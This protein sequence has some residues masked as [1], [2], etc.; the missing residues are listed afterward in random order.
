MISQREPWRRLWETRAGA[1][2]WALVLTAAGLSGCRS[3]P[4]PHLVDLAEPGWHVRQGQAVWTTDRGAVGVAGDLVVAVKTDASCWV[5]FSKP[6]FNLVTAQARPDG[7]RI[8]LHS[9]HIDYRGRGIP[10]RRF[11]WFQLAQVIAGRSVACE[12]QLTHQPGESWLFVH[13]E[14]GERLEV[15]LEP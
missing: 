4:R 13:A 3:T 6:P 2:G 15:H 9:Q 5:E 10:P 7:W 1:L 14:N 11:V 12:W 8:S